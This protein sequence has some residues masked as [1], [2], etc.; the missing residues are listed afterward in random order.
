[1]DTYLFVNGECQGNVRLPA[2]F[3]AANGAYILTDDE[4]RVLMAAQDNDV[5]QEPD[6][7]KA[8]ETPEEYHIRMAKA[9]EY[10][11]T[12]NEGGEGYNPYR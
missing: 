12:Y 10:D 11:N 1:M 7:P 6:A 4:Y 3:P 9:H 2:G 8:I 5:K